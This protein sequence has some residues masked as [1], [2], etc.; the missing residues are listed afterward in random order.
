M[1]AGR[2]SAAVGPELELLAFA[3]G[4]KP[5]LRLSFDPPRAMEAAARWRRRGFEVVEA[6]VGDATLLYLARDLATADALAQAEARILPGAGRALDRGA[7]AAAH[8]EL[9]RLLGYPACCA[10][11]FVDRVEAGV[12]RRHGGVA[13]AE[14]VV[15]AEDAASRTERFHARLNVMLRGRHALIP[16]DPC[17][18]DCPI[19]LRWAGAVLDAQRARRPESA[20]ALVEALLEPVRLAADATL[21][22]P[23]DPT[24]PVLLI[25]WDDV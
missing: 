13:I 23:R 12:T 18:F 22:D 1:T 11:A 8:R 2:A 21:L 19:A 5:T 15:A 7:A 6:S 4:I 9:G 25:R 24:P 20:A 10:D 3:L 17:R 14:L 16:F